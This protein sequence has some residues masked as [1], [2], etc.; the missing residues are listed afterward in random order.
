MDD[1]FDPV[2]LK[3]QADTQSFR[4]EIGAMRAELESGLSDG[5]A[6]A[7]NR[8]AR[9]LAQ[10]AR[11]GKMEFE[12]LARTA[13]RAL[14][15]VAAAA[16]RV[17]TTPSRVEAG[18]LSGLLSG[19]VT[20]G[21]G[22]PGRATGGPVSPGQAYMVGERGPELFIPTSSG[23]GHTVSRSRPCHSECKRKRQRFGP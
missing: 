20:Q 11:S 18:G 10:A 2:L 9:S 1:D 8:V 7:G 22:L 12:D 19:L 6:T 23:R 4:K 21:A 3:V 15:D 5:A 17:D 16:L 14:G 13:M